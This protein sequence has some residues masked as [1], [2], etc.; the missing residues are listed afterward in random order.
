MQ[1]RKAHANGVVRNGGLQCH[2]EAAKRFERSEL[3]LEKSRKII[4]RGLQP[5]QG[6]Q[7]RLDSLRVPFLRMQQHLPATPGSLSHPA[8][9]GHL[10]KFGEYMVPPELPAKHVEGPGVACLL[11]KPCGKAFKALPLH[12]DIRITITPCIKQALHL[13]ECG[14]LQHS[15]HRAE[16]FTDD[17]VR[18]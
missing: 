5:H 15:I 10:L 3:T 14:V 16:G 1:R 12:E 4:P 8:I 7:T 13:G 17:L 2:I 6:R 18:T 9:G 11:A